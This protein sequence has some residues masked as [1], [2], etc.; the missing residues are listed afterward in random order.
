MLRIPK[1]DVLHIVSVSIG[2]SGADDNIDGFTPP[3]QGGVGR[4]K[5]IC[6]IY[7]DV[8][9]TGKEFRVADDVTI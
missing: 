1:R 8:H 7:A 5:T 9:Y 6:A 3:H 2:Q 4:C